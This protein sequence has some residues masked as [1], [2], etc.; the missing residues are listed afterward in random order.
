MADRGGLT[1]RL[2]GEDNVVVAISEI[3]AG[4]LVAEESVTVSESIP[5]GHKI[6][7][8]PIPAD[9]AVIK[10]GQI[11]GFASQPLAPGQHAHVHT[12]GVHDFQR[13]TE[14]CVDAKPTDFVAEQERATF[15]GF[16]RRNGKVGTRNYLGILTASNCAASV[17]H[18]I[19]RQFDSG[20][21]HDYPNIDGVVA[22]GHGTGCGTV[23]GGEG[24]VLLQRVQHG[25]L[26]NP[27]F[28]GILLVGLGCEKNLN[29]HFLE[30]YGLETGKTFRTLTIQAE[31][32]TRRTV[33]RGVEL[34]RDMLPA[35]N[36]VRRETVSASE[37]VLALQCGGSDAYS[38]ITSNPALGVAADR[39][40]SQGGTVI[41]SETPEIYGAEHLLM[42]RAASPDVAEKLAD[43]IRWWERYVENNGG[44]MDNNPSPGN[45]A[46]GLTTIY[47]KSLGAAAK[48]GITRLEEVIGYAEPYSRRGLVFMDAPGY[49]PCAIT[50]QVASGSNLVCFT[51]GRGSV[52]GGKPVPCVK[53][54]SNTRLYDHLEEDMDINCGP[55]IDEGMSIEA[56]GDVIFRRLLEVASGDPSKSEALGMGDH[57]FV[58]WLI[59][60]VV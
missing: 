46:G 17:G 21:L 5:A 50:G 51:T 60:A 30:A 29:E 24:H 44:V 49:D 38:G 31:G 48:G 59:G 10:Y 45:I 54:A 3:G 7:T 11:I 23:A 40:V 20:L 55:V 47:E 33:E 9:G 19:A 37:L 56:M 18:F 8:A 32:G 1:I 4:T 41:L 15:R 43:Q 22:F 25:Y 52:F 35:A 2:H 36:D 26:Q 27:N 58:P 53:L 16:R 13:D 34:L 57:E 42:R 28:A 6:V 12:M 14:F 39:I